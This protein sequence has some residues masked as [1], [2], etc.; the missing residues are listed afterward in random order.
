MRSWP[1]RCW[2]LEA[3]AE[4]GRPHDGGTGF[5]RQMYSLSL[6]IISCA[7]ALRAG[8]L[9]KAAAVAM[10]EQTACAAVRSNVGCLKQE[11][12]EEAS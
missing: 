3:G 12:K 11:Q 4:R 1:Q 10:A 6:F 9:P 8:A 5:L 2:P 7:P